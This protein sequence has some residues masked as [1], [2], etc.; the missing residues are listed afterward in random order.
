MVADIVIHVKPSRKEKAVALDTF[1][2]IANQYDSEADALADFDDVRK[3]Y[4]ELG[5]IDTYDAAVLTHKA[6]GKVDI[7]KRVEEPTR[8]G[9]ALGLLGGLA[10]GAAVALFPAA[11]IPLAAG[12]L[13]GGALGAVTG[14]LA[15]HVAGGMSRS[16]LKELGELLDAGSSG[17]LVVA[18]ADVAGRVEAAASRAKKQ[19]KARLQADTDALKQEIDALGKTPA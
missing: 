2:V 4:T 11:A 6:D 10:I 15:G 14:A 5:V 19:A 18:A 13:G 16:D 9:A 1:V 12:A 3:L 8:Q 17:L 7:V